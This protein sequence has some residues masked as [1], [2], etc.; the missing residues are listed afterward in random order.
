MGLLCAKPPAVPEQLLVHWPLQPGDW[1]MLLQQRLCRSGLLVHG[2][3]PNLLGERRVHQRPLQLQQRLLGA[4]LR[5]AALSEQL[6]WSW[7]LHLS[8]Q[9]PVQRAVRRHGLRQDRLQQREQWRAQQTPAVR[10]PDLGRERLLEARQVGSAHHLLQEPA[11]LLHNRFL[12]VRLQGRL[13][14]GIHWSLCPH[15][16]IRNSPAAV[17]LHAI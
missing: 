1:S 6:L 2:V 16:D 5:H 9:V 13:L 11:R 12:A 7:P 3:H 4:G 10:L 15:S 14:C 17:D 8:R